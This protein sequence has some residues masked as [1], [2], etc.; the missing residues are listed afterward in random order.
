MAI[1]GSES[2][3]SIG[4]DRAALVAVLV[5]VFAVTLAN[6]KPGRDSLFDTQ[7]VDIAFNM[8]TLGVFAL[9][10]DEAG[11]AVPTAVREPVQPAFLAIA[12]AVFLDPDAAGARCL[13]EHPSSCPELLGPLKIVQALTMV[14]LALLI[15]GATV[16]LCGRGWWAVIAVV[17]FL[18]QGDAIRD[19]AITFMSEPTAALLLIVH[20]SLLALVA[21]DP[22]RRL[23][24]ALAGVAL[25]LLVL[26]KAIFIFYIV[27]GLGLLIVLA[28]FTRARRLAAFRPAAIVLLIAFAIMSAWIVRNIVVADT[29]LLTQR[30]NGV[31]VRRVE[32]ATMGWNESASSFVY[33]APYVG[34]A[35]AEAWLAPEHYVRLDGEYPGGYHARMRDG[36]GL[37]N[38]RTAAN[39]A[40]TGGR[41]ATLIRIVTPLQVMIEN[42]P[43]HLVLTISFLWRGMGMTVFDRW[44]GIA[45][46][47]GIIGVGARIFTILLVPAVI[48][49]AIRA[50]RR[51][52]WPVLVFLLPGLY[53][54][55]IHAFITHNLPRFNAP[56]IP[57]AI[58]ALVWLLHSLTAARRETAAGQP[59]RPKRQ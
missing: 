35:A 23:A 8:V 54:I 55:L 7:F 27:G 16:R 24:A 4:F 21:Q 1:I 10:R 51:R 44:T 56:V 39:L 19:A 5:V 45:V 42:M 15:Y 25:G 2:R 58:V 17:L 22:R 49:A 43:K 59:R 29:P 37:V 36:G 47:D 26:T 46:I 20:A 31:L 52:Q 11:D 38:A 3:R 6:S 30:G 41:F 28:P 33:Y 9:E 34:R 40:E 32:H 53:S 48:W 12:L 50:R 57:C 13:F 18:F 14:A